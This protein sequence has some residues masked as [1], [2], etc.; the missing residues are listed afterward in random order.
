MD[1]R[2]LDYYNQELS[3]IKELGQEFAQEHP[4]IA[5]RLGMNGADVADPFVERLLEGFALLTARIQLK[6]DAEFPKFSQRLLSIIYPHYLSPT[7]SIGV[8]KLHA[9]DNDSGLNKPFK[10]PR[11]TIIRAPI[12][13]G[14]VTSCQ[15]LTAQDVELL[16]ISIKNAWIEG[17]SIDIHTPK[18]LK[19]C[20][21]LH[22]EFESFHH[23]PINGIGFDDLPIYIAAPL[24]RALFLLE[25]ICGR[26]VGI[27]ISWKD[28]DHD[29]YSM[30]PNHQ[31]DIMGFD[32]EEAL[33]PY[34]GKSFSG[35]RSIHE[36][37]AT[38]DRFRFF[39][40]KKLKKFL[41]SNRTSKFKIIL[42]FDKEA[43]V[44]EK[45]ID[46][47]S[48]SLF[49]TPIINLFPKRGD[50]IDVSM[51]HNEYHL[52]ADKA[53]PL[54]YEIYSV[55]KIQGF[56]S[57]NTETQ[58]FLP[59]YETIG[60][61]AHIKYQAYFSIRRE[62]RQLSEAA[63]RSGPRTGYIGSEVFVQL[64]DR[65]DSPYSESLHRI[66]PE[67]LCTNRD[68]PLLL[69]SPTDRNMSLTIS[70]PVKQVEL[71]TNLTRPTPAIAEMHVTWKL[72]SHLQL[73]YQ[74]LT[75][76]SPEDG[77]KVIR[78]LLNIYAVFNNQ[79]YSREANSIVSISIA[80]KVFRIQ[81]KGPLLFAKG[82]VI[83]L[84][85]D[86]EKFEGASPWLFGAVLERFFVRH[87]GI[88]CAIQFK[89][90][91][92]QNGLFSE[93]PVRIGNRPNA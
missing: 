34:G 65:N 80:S 83:Q 32:A 75:D 81:E 23:I 45:L 85:L 78:E 53:R 24:E 15:F 82:V 50:R 79:E 87:V 10:I 4:K 28:V 63:K 21:S 16:P 36:Y 52:V 73:N 48:F 67:M 29:H 60:S 22:L 46:P 88:N 68:L 9:S 56:S 44:L 39:K 58:E 18:S 26:R 77:A 89:M 12:P 55:S 72:I 35:Y 86:E 42:Y 6:M 59:L 93:W 25:L 33:I 13:Y 66:A 31:V 14:Q 40:I 41:A 2:L 38:P 1:P 54:D 8:I 92:I 43:Q 76:S 91:T 57:G 5:A 37:F 61:M 20:S 64:V 30:I 27:A 51:S 17:Q 71:V 19:I 47:T 62:P 69:V 90:F 84:V 7:P 74:T 3:F 11:H 70:A 49:C